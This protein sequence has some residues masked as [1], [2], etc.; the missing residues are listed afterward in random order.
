M[1]AAMQAIG[2]T[3]SEKEP[4]NAGPKSPPVETQKY[5]TYITYPKIQT[6]E[7]MYYHIYSILIYSYHLFSL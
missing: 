7:Y 3:P 2:A 4:V 6:F 5:V 1:T